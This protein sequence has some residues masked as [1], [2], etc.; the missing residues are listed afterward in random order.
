MGIQCLHLSFSGG[1]FRYFL[2]RFWKNSSVLR[3]TSPLTPRCLYP[4]SG[5]S[6]VRCCFFGAP[7]QYRLHKTCSAAAWTYNYILSVQY[8]DCL[9]LILFPKPP[10]K[11][12]AANQV[13][14]Y[15]NQFT[16][17]LAA[18]DSVMPY[19]DKA[20]WRNM[21]KETA[22]KFNP[23]QSQFFPLAAAFVIRYFM[24]TVVSSMRR[25]RLLLAAIRCV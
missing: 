17:V 12:A 2:L 23:I 1:C 13:S 15:R 4:I 3:H 6:I 24:A 22:D 5:C 7:I 8:L 19:P 25:I 11:L 16:L 9:C 21:H 14:A 10:Q 20:F 18:Q